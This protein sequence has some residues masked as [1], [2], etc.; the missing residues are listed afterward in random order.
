M[1]AKMVQRRRSGQA[2]AH[3]VIVEGEVPVRVRY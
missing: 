3:L 1:G 2:G